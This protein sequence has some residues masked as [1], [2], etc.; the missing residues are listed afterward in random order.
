M[1]RDA[2]KLWFETCNELEAVLKAKEETVRTIADELIRKETIR[3]RR[4]AYLL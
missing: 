2:K 3:S 1:Q 4:L